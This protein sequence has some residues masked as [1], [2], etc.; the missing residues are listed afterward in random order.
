MKR[1]AAGLLALGLVG[2]KPP[3]NAPP[4][5]NTLAVGLDISA[6]FRKSWY[7]D[8]AM[9]Y[10][11][12]YIY[13]HV[14]GIGGLKQTTDVFVGS[15]GGEHVGQPKSFHPIQDLTQKT[16]EQIEADLR[17]WFPEDDPITDFNAFF[18]RTA[19]RW[20]NA[21]KSVIGSSSGNQDRR[22]ASICSGVF[23]VRSWIGWKLFGCPTCSPPSE[24]TKTSGV[25]LSP[26]MPFTCAAKE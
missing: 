23:W 11:S 18:Q 4:P 9:R 17:S 6:S 15:L 20:K 3:A 19:V 26:A 2:C 7:F 12:L 1:L 13:A 21:L 10:A 14:N 8:E 24:P 5:R 25:F 22:S 16:P